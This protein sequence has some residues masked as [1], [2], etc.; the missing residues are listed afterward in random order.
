MVD[1]LE[2]SFD[3]QRVFESIPVDQL[4]AEITSGLDAG[5][6]VK[7]E[8]TPSSAKVTIMQPSGAGQTMGCDWS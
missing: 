2:Y 5:N 3:F 1:P 7:V 6:T 8:Y 4:T